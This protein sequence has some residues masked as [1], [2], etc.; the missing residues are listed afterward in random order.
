MKPLQKAATSV[1][2]LVFITS[3]LAGFLAPASYETQFRES[4]SA[5][6][7]K[8]FL[9]GTDELGRDR[10]SR[11]LHGTRVSLLLAPAAALL[12]T[13]GAAM[14]GGTAGY[15]GTWWD[16]SAT[17][18]TDLFLS[19]PW[20]F[21]LLTVR[22]LLPLN[23]SPL[24]SVVVTFA[25]LGLLGWAASARI[26][27]SGALSLRTSDFVLQA[28]ALG[29][30]KSRIF[31]RQVLPN[32]KPVLKAQFWISIPAFILAEA[33]LGLLG[34]GVAEPLPSWGNLLRELENYSAV[35][36]NPW[37]L[38]PLALLVTVVACFQLILSKEDTL[39]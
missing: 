29:I 27:R 19:L 14:V 34:L 16:R 33:N 36:A 38:T 5:L 1:L 7:S 8:Q 2:G 4:P 20:L 3:L 12:A 9:L 11:L 26:V 6:P 22:A 17:S 30:R 13:L 31:V 18:L 32:L 10:F 24:A 28:R 25:L 21:L 37:L 39:Q 35:R 15:F 23:V